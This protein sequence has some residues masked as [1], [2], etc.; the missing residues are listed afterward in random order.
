MQHEIMECSPKESEDGAR[1]SP[2]EWM[3][4]HPCSLDPSAR[5]SF[6]EIFD[7]F[8]RCEFEIVPGANSKEIQESVSEVLAAEKNLWSGR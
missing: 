2:W 5:P 4:D 1:T 7:E 8:R 6:N 3:T